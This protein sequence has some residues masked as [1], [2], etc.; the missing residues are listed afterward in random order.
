MAGYKRSRICPSVRSMKRPETRGVPISYHTRDIFVAIAEC[1]CNILSPIKR[2]SH[3]DRFWVTI[4]GLIRVR[5]LEQY[6]NQRDE[7]VPRGV[8]V[9]KV[10]VNPLRLLTP[11][12]RQFPRTQKR[13]SLPLLNP[14]EKGLGMVTTCPSRLSQKSRPYLSGCSRSHPNS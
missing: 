6:K 3:E 2:C 10:I 11:V 1:R 13:L 8:Y 5:S 4:R 9:P 14:R 7:L 12:A